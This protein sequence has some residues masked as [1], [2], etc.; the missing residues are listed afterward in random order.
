MSYTFD[1]VKPGNYMAHMPALD[2]GDTKVSVHVEEWT[3]FGTNQKEKLVC[4]NHGTCKGQYATDRQLKNA[5]F[6]DQ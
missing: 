3:K 6:Y 5:V 1:E 4:F 2:I